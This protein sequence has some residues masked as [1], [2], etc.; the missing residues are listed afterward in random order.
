VLAWGAGLEFPSS[1]RV[2]VVEGG[3][4]YWTADSYLFRCPTSGCLLGGDLLATGLARHQGV[5]PAFA[6]DAQALYWAQR[7]TSPAGMIFRLG[8]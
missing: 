7:T 1:T 2:R 3:Q 8:R 5:D 6:I 4:L